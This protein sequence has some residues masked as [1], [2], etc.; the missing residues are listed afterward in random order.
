ML[1]AKPQLNGNERRD[2]RAAAQAMKA[3]H[4]QLTS[5]MRVL[6]TNV[7]HGRNYQHTDPRNRNVDL[8]SITPIGKAMTRMESLIEELTLA[9]TDQRQAVLDMIA[10]RETG[11]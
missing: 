8:D 7:L 9:G 3:A 10:K 1:H 5:A 2:F 11:E 6:H 4:D